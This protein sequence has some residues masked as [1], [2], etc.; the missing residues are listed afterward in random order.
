MFGD[1]SFTI[2]QI[3]RNLSLDDEVW[4]LKVMVEGLPVTS[5]TNYRLPPSIIIRYEDDALASC[6]PQQPPPAD[7]SYQDY[8]KY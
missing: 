7:L 3:H 8:F 1:V 2:L 6:S 4:S 5:L